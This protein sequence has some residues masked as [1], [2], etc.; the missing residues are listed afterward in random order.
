MCSSIRL[1]Q[2]LYLTLELRGQK[3]PAE[4]WLGKLPVMGNHSWGLWWQSVF[5][6][7]RAKD[8]GTRTSWVRMEE[9]LKVSLGSSF[10]RLS[11]KASWTDSQYYGVQGL[12]V[13]Y[14]WLVI[15][16]SNT[17]NWTDLE[18]PTIVTY[19]QKIMLLK[20]HCEAPCSPELERLRKTDHEFEVSLDCYKTW[21][22]K[23]QKT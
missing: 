17:H 13:S 20:I 8:Q 12:T 6:P 16:K 10:P 19:E 15:L 18:N 2:I 21:S 7:W 11:A 5:T 9:T 14:W 1:G 3:R 23:K 4:L 22:Q